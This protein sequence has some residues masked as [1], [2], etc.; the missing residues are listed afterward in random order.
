MTPEKALTVL[1]AAHRT[2]LAACGPRFADRPFQS[3]AAPGWRYLP[4]EDRVVPAEGFTCP[5]C[6]HVSYN[7]SDIAHRYCG[8]CHHFHGSPAWTKP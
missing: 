4:A 8:A 3:A 2:Y 1:R 7:R 6:G 5:D